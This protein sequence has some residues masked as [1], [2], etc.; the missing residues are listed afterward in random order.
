MDPFS[1]LN[2]IINLETN[3]IDNN[4]IEN[5]YNDIILTNISDNI[6]N[7]N[8]IQSKR[9][10]KKIKYINKTN[11]KSNNKRIITNTLI[12]KFKSI[13]DH[14]YIIGGIVW[15]TNRGFNITDNF[16]ICYDRMVHQKIIKSSNIKCFERRASLVGYAHKEKSYFKKLTLSS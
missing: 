11:K 8:I 14:L 6:K 3:T 1:D 4:Y 12:Q 10:I 7:N 5:Y 9:N 13:L 2:D 15:T 16:Q